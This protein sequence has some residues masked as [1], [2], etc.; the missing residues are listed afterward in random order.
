WTTHWMAIKTAV[1]D[2]LCPNKNQ[3]NAHVALFRLLTS[4]YSVFYEPRAVVW[5]ENY[6][7]R[8]SFRRSLTISRRNLGR[9]CAQIALGRHGPRK[10]FLSMAA[11]W[12]VRR[13]R[14]LLKWLLGRELYPPTAVLTEMYYFYAGVIGELW[15]TVILTLARGGVRCA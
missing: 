8:A 13:A 15:D 7:T 9:F 14:R 11:R 6:T 12:T 4:G 5:R 3:R 2:D 10:R 1:L